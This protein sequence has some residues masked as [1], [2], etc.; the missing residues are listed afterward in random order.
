[1]LF[2]DEKQ[3]LEFIETV[4]KPAWITGPAGSGKT[5]VMAL[6]NATGYKCLDL[7]WYGGRVSFRKTSSRVEW[8]KFVNP[9]DPATFRYLSVHLP[10]VQ[11][12]GLVVKW[13]G[14]KIA[15]VKIWDLRDHS[16]EE[17]IAKWSTSEPSPVV[18]EEIKQ[19]VNH[20]LYNRLSLGLEFFSFPWVVDTEHPDLKKDIDFYAG[21]C[22]NEFDVADMGPKTIIMVR[23]RYEQRVKAMQ[24]RAQHSK[25]ADAAKW[26]ELAQMSRSA[27][28]RFYDEKE[29]KLRILAFYAKA[30]LFVVT[31][32]K[33]DLPPE[34]WLSLDAAKII[35]S[36]VKSLGLRQSKK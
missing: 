24:I 33:L 35:N 17:T 27:F 28:E 6:L 15:S 21:T 10:D 18:Q 30:P 1:M 26:R 13:I 9:K 25:A 23:P 5:T 34:G 22:S 16:L 2:K 8:Q 29:E 36:R 3:F 12:I 11:P 7:D 20:E 31:P 14:G 32:P 4:R 19:I